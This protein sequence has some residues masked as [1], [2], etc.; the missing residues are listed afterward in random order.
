LAEG[1][2]ERGR[3]RVVLDERGEVF[4][5]RQSGVAQ[6]ADVDVIAPG[7]AFAVSLNN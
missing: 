7:D 4:V 1:D 3:R 2:A 5:Q 6:L